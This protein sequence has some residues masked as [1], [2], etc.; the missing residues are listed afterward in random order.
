MHRLLAR[1]WVRLG[2]PALALGGALLAPL[3]PAS[4]ADLKMA[5]GYPDA[6]YLTLT[7]RD[8]IA[9][10]DKRT[11]GALKIELHNNQSLVKLP[12]MMR[13]VQ[14]GQVALADVRLGNYGNQDPVYI[15][16]AIPFVAGDYDSALKLWQASKPYLADSFAKRGMKVLF[17]MWNPPQGF[18]TLKPVASAA[19]LAGLKLRIYSTETRRMGELLK[20]EPLIVQFGEVPQAFSTGL[21][22]AMFTSP[23]TGIDTQ[24]WDF[25]KNLTMVGALYTKQLVA[26]NSDVFDKLPKAQQDAVVAAGAAAEKAGFERMKALTNEQLAQIKG[27]GIQVADGSPALIGQLKQVGTQMQDEWK[28]KAAPE[29]RTVLENYAKLM[30]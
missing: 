11:G 14:T 8:F 18:Y 17:A 28:A 4:A 25:V 23:Q 30:K 12:D 2:L 1:I 22:N 5:S 24:A 20:A 15:L 7:V 9:D 6:N 21:I 29:Q 10:V 3:A 26:I 19:D 13:A 16:D 27:K